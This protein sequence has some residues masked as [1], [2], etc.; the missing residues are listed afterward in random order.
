MLI[1]VLTNKLS[2]RGALQTSH[3]NELI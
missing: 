1:I 3:S 2:R